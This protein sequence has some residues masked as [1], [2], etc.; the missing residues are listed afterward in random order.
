[1]RSI[2]LFGAVFAVLGACAV[3]TETHEAEIHG[4]HTHVHGDDCGHAKVWHVDHWDYLHDGHL[5]FVH[6][7]HVDEHVLEVTE[8]NPAGEAPMAPE[9]HA[10]HMHGAG[11]GHMMVPHGDHFDYVH[12]GHLHYVHGD[13]VDDHGPVTVEENG[14]A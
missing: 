5:H 14:G 13:H 8:L 12:D 11:D 3:V 2:V 10:D 4:D 7:G 6:E 1:M 9:L